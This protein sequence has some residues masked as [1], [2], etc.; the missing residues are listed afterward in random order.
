LTGIKAAILSGGTS[1]FKGITLA[2]GDLD[3]GAGSHKIKR[4]THPP[5]N[6]MDTLHAQ[7]STAGRSAAQPLPARD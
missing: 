3:F 5:E 6:R 2:C 4:K 7:V 1:C